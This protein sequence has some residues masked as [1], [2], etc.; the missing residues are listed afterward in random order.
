MQESGFACRVAGVPQG[1]D[2]LAEA[3][4]DQHSARPS[5]LRD[6]LV[7]SSD[8]AGN[9]SHDLFLADLAG[10]GIRALRESPEQDE[11]APR[12]SPDGERI[13]AVA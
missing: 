5:P 3:S 4:F 11:Y 13:A 9:G 2:E 12:W 8:R 7:F 1:V 10:G 6:E